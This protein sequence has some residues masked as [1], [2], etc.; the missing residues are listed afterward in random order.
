MHKQIEALFED[1]ESRYLM[2]EELNVL[3]QYVDSVPSRLNAYRTLRDHEIQIMQ[4]IADQLQQEFPQASVDKLERSIKNGLL[5]LRYCAMAMLLNDESF[6]QDR[7]RGWL[8]QASK[9]YD[10]HAIDMSLYRQLSQQLD[11]R[12]PP[13]QAALIQ[14]LIKVVQDLLAQS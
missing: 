5:A 8:D 7:V 6:L 9:V 11:Q 10:T 4:P 1:A 12:L 3:S 13:Q 14:P 2:P